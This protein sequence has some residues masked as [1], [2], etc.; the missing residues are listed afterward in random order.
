[1]RP[2][3]HRKTVRTYK[4]VKGEN[5]RASPPSCP[6]T[7][8]ANTERQW[9]SDEANIVRGSKTLLR[10]NGCL[11]IADGNKE[12]FHSVNGDVTQLVIRNV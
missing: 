5:V 3:S 7:I 2:N 8:D 9:V 4:I 1:M 6:F 12:Q 10:V 11:H